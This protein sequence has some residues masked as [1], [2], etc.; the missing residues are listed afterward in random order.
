MLA[1]LAALGAV[2]AFIR[3]DPETRQRKASAPSLPPSHEPLARPAT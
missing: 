3:N 2:M 1:A